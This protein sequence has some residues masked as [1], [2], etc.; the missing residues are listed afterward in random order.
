M[1]LTGPINKCDMINGFGLRVSIFV[2]GCEHGCPECFSKYTWD[3][4]TGYEFTDEIKE[5]IMKACSK[6]HIDGLSILGGDPLATFN[7]EEILSFCKEFK[8][9]FPMK[10]I[11]IWTGYDSKDVLESMQEI[12]DVANVI[13]TGK[14]DSKYTDDKRKLLYRGSY[15]QEYLV[16]GK[17]FSD[18]PAVDDDE[19]IDCS[20]CDYSDE[21]GNSSIWGCHHEENYGTPIKMNYNKCKNYEN[22]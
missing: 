22:I 7:Y 1:N 16:N 21:L 3:K 4:N 15:N 13:I 19:M 11:Y 17:V 12:V 6:D 2:S 14:F 18:F 10:T 9:R 5:E 8:K 20:T